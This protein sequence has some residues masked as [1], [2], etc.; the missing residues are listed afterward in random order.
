MTKKLYKTFIIFFY[1]LSFIFLFSN[2]NATQINKI[3]IKGNERISDETIILFS[4]FNI[5]S[6]ITNNKLNQIIKNLFETNFFEDI[7]V[8]VLDQNLLITVVEAPIIDK[9]E[10]AG[11]KSESIKDSLNSFIN[12]ILAIFTFVGHMIAS[13]Q[14]GNSHFDIYLF[15][16][17]G[18]AGFIGSY[19]GSKHINYYSNKF[20]LITLYIILFIMGILMVFREFV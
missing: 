1:I 20:I 3:Q 4:E 2:S 13:Q 15:M 14:S 16:P 6:E 5:G 19:F 17:L 11:I 10:F 9:V 12:L 18:L 8:K 7:N